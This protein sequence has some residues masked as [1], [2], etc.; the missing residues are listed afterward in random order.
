MPETPEGLQP[1]IRELCS[2]RFDEILSFRETALDPNRTEGIHAMRVA[3][4]RL[5]SLIDDLKGIGPGLDSRSFA[6]KLK[7][8]GNSLG[9]VR[10]ADVGIQSLRKF[11]EKTDDTEVVI[12]I[13]AFID[14]LCEERQQSFLK[15]EPDLSAEKMEKLQRRSDGYIGK[16]DASKSFNSDRVDEVGNKI[17]ARRVDEFL[18]LAPALYHPFQVRRLHKM[19]IA[20]K[21]L[22]YTV[23]TFTDQ[24]DESWSGRAAEI[25]KMQGYLGDLHDSDI[26]IDQLGSTLKQDFKIRADESERIAWAWLLSR[27]VRQRTSDY[28]SALG[29]WTSWERSGFLDSI[30]DNRQ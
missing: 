22:R 14:R 29:L 18:K 4:R 21:Q 6:Q 3:I 15:L 5:R 30:R 2:V 11:R 27:F 12:G 9:A 28:R 1:W 10:D 7:K 8:L 20:G 26:W 16:I 19:R 24:T 17:I 25:A 13:N 23:E